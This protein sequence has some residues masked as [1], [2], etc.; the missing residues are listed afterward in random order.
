MCRILPYS[1]KYIKA[2]TKEG[3]PEKT[4]YIFVKGF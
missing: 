3:N 2:Q 4:S 1:L